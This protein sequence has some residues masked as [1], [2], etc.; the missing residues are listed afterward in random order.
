MKEIIQTF[1]VFYFLLIIIFS[2]SFYLLLQYP[3]KFIILRSLLSRLYFIKSIKSNDIVYQSS[4]EGCGFATIQML[5]NRLRIT[6]TLTDDLNFNYNTSLDMNTMS[7]II[8]SSGV[9]TTGYEFA[10]IGQLEK[11]FQAN[12]S[13]NIILLMKRYDSIN[14][15]SFMTI[16]F[17]PV[18]IITEILNKLK[19]INYP[20]LHWVLLDKLSK[21]GV[22]LLDPFFGKIILTSNRFKSCWS[23]YGLIINK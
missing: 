20:D 12:H 23:N 19:L 17:S 10:S 16:L 14:Q 21:K 2:F 18:Y 3:N 6:D 7:E 13:S 22:V 4:I 11:F 5:F 8:E 9:N 15:I 1:I